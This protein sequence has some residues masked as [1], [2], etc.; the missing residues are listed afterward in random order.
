MYM[1]NAA[2]ACQRLDV[3]PYGQLLR[4]TVYGLELPHP[5]DDP[6]DEVVLALQ[7]EGAHRNVFLVDDGGNPVWRIA[8]YEQFGL[9]DMFVDVCPSNE[10]GK[11]TGYTGRG[12]IFEIDLADGR[13]K[14]IG[15]TK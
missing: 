12:H 2:L 10:P 4:F 8:D 7:Q 13:L 11:A 5:P 6:Y 9:A 1:P 15:W 3:P 14:K